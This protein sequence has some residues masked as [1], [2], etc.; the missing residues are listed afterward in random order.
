[1]IKFLTLKRDLLYPKPHFLNIFNPIKRKIT[2][3]KFWKFSKYPNQY[4]F[5]GCNQPDSFVFQVF[6]GPHYCQEENFSSSWSNICW[7]ASCLIQQIIAPKYKD[8]VSLTITIRIGD[9]IMDW[10]LLDLGASVNLLPYSVYKRLGLGESQPTNLSLLLTNRS[11][12]IPKGIVEDVTLKVDEF[13][14]AV[15]FVVLDTESMTNPN[16]HSPVILERPFFATADAVIR[17]RNRVM[18]LSFGN[19]TVELNVFHTSSQPL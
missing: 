19:M 8:V 9:Q 18:T 3:R 14:F 7:Q 10:Y 13:Y 16:N 17:Y 6:K 2:V 12:K 5:L 15:D 4:F 1:M 11:V